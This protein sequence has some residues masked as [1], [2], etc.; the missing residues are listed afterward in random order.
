MEETNLK[1]QNF[2]NNL[3]EI[4]KEYNKYKERMENKINEHIK[5]EEELKLKQKIKKA[6]SKI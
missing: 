2:D 1:N 6:L 4:V 5:K 3:D